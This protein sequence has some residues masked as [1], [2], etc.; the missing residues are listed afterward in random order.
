V[1]EGSNLLEGAPT[2]AGPNARTRIYVNR[3]DLLR[4]DIIYRDHEGRKRP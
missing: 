4:A 1:R 2:L 3:R